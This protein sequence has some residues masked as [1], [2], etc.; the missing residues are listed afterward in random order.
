VSAQVIRFNRADAHGRHST[1]VL[2]LVVTAMVGFLL[3]PA[4]SGAATLASPT[5][6]VS[7]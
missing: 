2:A 7:C 6:T 4:S 3:I 5:Y 1:V